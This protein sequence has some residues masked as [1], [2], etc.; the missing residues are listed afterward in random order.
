M[1]KAIQMIMVVFASAFLLAAG[2]AEKPKA[3]EAGMAPGAE[4]GKGAGAGVGEAGLGDVPKSV[5]ESAAL[6]D[7]HF[8]FD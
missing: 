6:K 3:G 5:E 4:A 2:C 8:D 7:I 1:S